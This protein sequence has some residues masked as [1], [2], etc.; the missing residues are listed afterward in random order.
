MNGWDGR[1]TYTCP[2]HH[3]MN[4]LWSH[5]NNGKEDR[6]WKMNCKKINH[7]GGLRSCAWTGYQGWDAHGT[8]ECP[9]G[10]AIA[11]MDSYHDNGK[12]DRRYRWYCCQFSNVR[13][14]ATE[15]WSGWI[16]GWDGVLN[17]APPADAWWGGIHSIHDNGKE[18]RVFKRRWRRGYFTGG[19]WC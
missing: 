11:G 1:Y 16:N 4:H 18:D 9:H 19:V 3:V 7:P 17:H 15:G 13:N 8:W 14:I 5:H 10:G 12:E 2:A 6:Q